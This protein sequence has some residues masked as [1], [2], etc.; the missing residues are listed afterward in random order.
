MS[1]EIYQQ[2]LEKLFLPGWHC[3]AAAAQIPHVGDYRTIDVLGR[4]L[5]CWHTSNGFHT[6]LNVCTHR[7]STLTDCRQGRAEGRLKCQ[8]HGWEFDET[9]NTCKI[10]DAQSFRPLAKG[11]LGLREYRT[12]TVGQLI[13][14]SFQE[15]P[16]PLHEFL[17]DEIVALCED[18]FG[19]NGTII[20]T[21]DQELNCNWKIV[22]E[23]GV[24]SYHIETVHPKTFGHYPRCEECRHDFQRNYD[25][26]IHDYTAARLSPSTRNERILARLS[27][28]APE[29]RYHHLLR[30]PNVVF[31]CGAQVGYIQM[32]WPVTA[33]LTRG[34]S[35][36]MFQP[37][38]RRGIVSKLLHRLVKFN[39]APLIRRVISEDASIVPSI[40]RGTASLDRPYGGGLIS[41]REERI[42]AFQDRILEALGEKHPG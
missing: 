24:E 23:N 28:V 5:I 18:W 9:G 11:E 10:P 30:Y 27:G 34:F 39:G 21:I 32:Y 36:F 8:Y 31:G 7:F 20:Y 25:H 4:P 12:E 22:I 6:Y 40:H 35:L 38:R 15:N 26:F 13:F 42:F 41:I 37:G 16:I 1:E 19:S 29:L 14:V 33:K 2:E 3:I 17:G